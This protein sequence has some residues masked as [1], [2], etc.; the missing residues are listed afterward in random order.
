[1]PQSVQDLCRRLARHRV[2]E[3]CKLSQKLLTFLRT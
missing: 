1:L 3:T 2:E